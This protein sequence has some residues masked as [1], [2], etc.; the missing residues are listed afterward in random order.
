MNRKRDLI[1]RASVALVCAVISF[2][3]IQCAL[4]ALIESWRPR[5]AYD[6]EY[7][8][9]LAQLHA[10]LAE[11]KDG[12]P[13]VVVFGS[14]RIATGFRP[15]SLASTQNPE[16]GT[17]RIFNIGICQWVSPATQSIVLHRLLRQGI[18]PDYVLFEI[19]PAVIA[20]GPEPVN[21]LNL[22][23][24]DWSDLEIVRP[25]ATAS[26]K[27]RVNWV[28]ARVVP[29][30]SERF[31]LLSRYAPKWVEQNKEV[32]FNWARLGDWGWTCL[33]NYNVAYGVTKQIKAGYKPA[34]EQCFMSE[35]SRRIY[36]DMFEFCRKSNIGVGLVLMPEHG[37]FRELYSPASEQRL[38]TSLNDLKARFD[39]S[40]IDARA[41]MPNGAFVEG[42]HLTHA[43]AAAFTQIFDTKVLQPMP[44]SRAEAGGK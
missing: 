36:Q 3:L 13:L 25:Y 42:V 30:F 35:T 39:G 44:I 34:L 4:I 24:L 18:R 14:S 43:G 40:I 15:E 5:P 29:A 22:T 33:P 9:K 28:V 7:A 21:S 27:Q 19:F 32:N 20:A 10:R 17:P 2:A 8:H 31:L 6:P 38:Q 12:G 23:R 1:R 37:E 26:L 41:W 16:P 11:T